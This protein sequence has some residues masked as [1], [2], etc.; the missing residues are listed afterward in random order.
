M[1]TYDEIHIENLQI[2]ANHGVFPE[3]TA[4]GQKFI[5]SAVLYTET[6]EAGK[7][8][9]LEDSTHYGEVS[10]FITGFLQKNT[11]KLIE[12]AAE[13]TAEAVLLAYPM[14]EGID[15]EIKKPW[16]PVKLPLDYV[17]VKISRF[18]HRAYIALGSNMGDKKAYLDMAVSRLNQRDDTQVVKVSDYIVTAPYGGVAQ[19]DFLNGALELRTLL[20]PEELLEML[21]SIEA[22]ADRK[23]EIRWGPRTLDLDILLYDDLVYGSED[24]IIPHIEMHKRDFV[25][26]PLAQIAPWVRHPVFGKTVTEMAEE[27]SE[28]EST[29]TMKTV[30]TVKEK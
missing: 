7:T 21:H 17:S 24:L 16:A 2:F 19:D 1:R 5:V 30:E 12:A 23:R 14:V 27:V 29:G 22:D 4:L 13:H 9:A 20:E 15:L 26:R 3:E 28:A 10:Q 11:Y 6:R 8:D 25:L 18:W